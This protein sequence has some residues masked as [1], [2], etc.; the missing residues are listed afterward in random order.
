MDTQN[1]DLETIG[2]AASLCNEDLAAAFHQNR[3]RLT[4]MVRLRMD[5]R[6]QGRL[7]VSDVLQDAFVEC[8]RRLPEYRA[9]PV[10]PLF[11]WIRFL[12]GQKLTDLQRA[13]LGAKM[14]A[15]GQE[16]SANF[17]DASSI[18][19]AAQLMGKLTS[20]SQ[21][22]VRAENQHRIR[23]ALEAMDPIDREVLA[24]RHFE[25]LTNEETSQVLGLRKSAASNRYIRALRRIKAI[26]LEKS[27]HD[28]GH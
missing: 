12:T 5:G 7:D 4:Q 2:Q 8:L 26:L 18:S 19:L 28:S 23:Q 13:H 1:P 11:L 16:V 3:Q 14:R 20:P 27:V 6:L 17:P 15:A 9:K 24:L 21:A 10:L 22:A 25:M